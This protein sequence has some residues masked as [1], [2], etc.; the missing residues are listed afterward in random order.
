MPS[1][2]TALEIQIYKVRDKAQGSTFSKMSLD[3]FAAKM[4]PDVRA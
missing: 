1:G 3:I 2:A 4:Q